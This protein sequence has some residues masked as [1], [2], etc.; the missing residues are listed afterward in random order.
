MGTKQ[1]V[2]VGTSESLRQPSRKKGLE[3]WA[4]GFS[5]QRS[6]AS[7]GITSKSSLKSHEKNR[8][9]KDYWWLAW[10]WCCHMWSKPRGHPLS[11]VLTRQWTWSLRLW[12]MIA[13]I[14][15]YSP[16][17][18]LLYQQEV[19]P[20]TSRTSQTLQFKISLLGETTPTEYAF[21]F[22]CD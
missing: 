5:Y 16:K 7:R 22:F 11:R 8:E 1:T 18:T 10:L 15:E 3:N 4:H 20:K 6:E 13:L 9:Q 17:T 19:D 2:L 21:C 12:L 14:K